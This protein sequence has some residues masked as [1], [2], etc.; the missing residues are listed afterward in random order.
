MGVRKFDENDICNIRALIYGEWTDKEISTLYHVTPPTIRDIRLGRTYK[1]RRQK[2]SEK[3]VARIK[4]SLMRGVKQR[5]L[6]KLHGV[7]QPTI[8]DIDRGVT[9]K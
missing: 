3:Q 4:N 5:I 7:S 2:L 9:W 8:S 6:A 1:K